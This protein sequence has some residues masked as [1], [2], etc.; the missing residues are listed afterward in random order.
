MLRAIDFFFY[1]FWV[2]MKLAFGLDLLWNR[3]ILG[4]YSLNVK[5]TDF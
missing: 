3:F 5:Y 4:F 2:Y 1:Y